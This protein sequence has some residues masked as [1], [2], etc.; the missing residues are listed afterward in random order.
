MTDDELK[1]ARLE[2]AREIGAKRWPAS[3]H[4]GVMDGDYDEADGV[5]CA[6]AALTEAN[7]Q[8]PV[9]P[10]MLI[11]REAAAIDWEKQNQPHT[12]QETREGLLDDWYGPQIALAAIKLYK[13]RAG[14]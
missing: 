10:D 5:V 7:W 9:D 14:A 6:L 2:K 11:A 13:S 4:D 1:Q 3:S 12:A 8:P